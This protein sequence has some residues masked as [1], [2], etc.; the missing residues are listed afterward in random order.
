MRAAEQKAHEL[1]GSRIQRWVLQSKP[2]VRGADGQEEAERRGSG[3]HQP[4]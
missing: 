4:P 3:S 2:K 1:E